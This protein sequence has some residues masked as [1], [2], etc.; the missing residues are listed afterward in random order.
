MCQVPPDLQGVLVGGQI[1]ADYK[2][3]IKAAFDTSKGSNQPQL[4]IN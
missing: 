4:L 2:K 1:K 3:Q